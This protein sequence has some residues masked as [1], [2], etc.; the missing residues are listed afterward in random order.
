MNKGVAMIWR[1][2]A[3]NAPAPSS[4]SPRRD[5][6]RGL[7]P[8]CAPRSAFTLLELLLVLALM[9]AIAAIVWPSL[10]G[11][12]ERQ[13]L[14]QSAEQLRAELGKTRVRAMRTGTIQVFRFQPGQS[15]FKSEPWT[16]SVEDANSSNASIG[17]GGAPAPPTLEAARTDNL[18]EGVIFHLAEVTIDA[19]AGQLLGPAGGDSAPG[20]LWS[21]P[22]FFYP[23]GT[24]SNT[25]I[26]LSNQRGQAIV[27]TLRGLTGLTLPSEVTTI[28]QLSR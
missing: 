24:T 5:T 26:V 4:E 21:D 6:R 13:R 15:G 1:W 20:A 28:E 9:V 18:S 14:S 23:D 27:V 17:F 16:L 25:H 19:R 8:R 12:F 2:S 11:P 3:N 7:R 22:I 10:K